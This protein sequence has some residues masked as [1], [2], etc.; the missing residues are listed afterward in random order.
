MDQHG[1]LDH[2]TILRPAAEHA[3]HCDAS[4]DALDSFIKSANEYL[5]KSRILTEK[6]FDL[7]DLKNNKLDPLVFNDKVCKCAVG[8][9][10]LR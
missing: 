1:H 9:S 4:N 2:S 5:E 10:E 7:F 8:N 6:T 3:P